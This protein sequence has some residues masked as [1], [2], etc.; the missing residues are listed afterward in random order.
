MSAPRPPLRLTVNPGTVRSA[1]PKLSTC[2]SRSSRRRDHR[3]AAAS[4][5]RAASRPARRHDHRFRDGLSASDT[6]SVRTSSAADRRRLVCAVKP[7]RV[8]QQAVGAGRQVRRRRTAPRRPC[9][10]SGAERTDDGHARRHDGPA[11]GIASRRRARRRPRTA[12]ARHEQDERRRTATR[13]CGRTKPIAGRSRRRQGAEVAWASF[14]RAHAPGSPGG[15]RSR[16]SR[17]QVS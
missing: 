7:L 9:T 1:S 12:T 2:R 16:T 11:L 6:S 15:D 10:R 17:D 8:G 3:H 13:N 14:R 4:R 5:C